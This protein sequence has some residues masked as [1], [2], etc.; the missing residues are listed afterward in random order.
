MKK[1]SCSVIICAAGKGERAGLGK[2]KLLFPLFGAPALYH[3]LKK[4]KTDWIDQVIVT[5]SRND[6][7]EISALCAPFGFETVIG[8]ATRT[9]S[10]KRALRYV[11]GEIVL[12]HDG[13]R[14]FVSE[15]LIKNCFLS[16]E[17]FGSG[18]AAVRFTDTAVYAAY[19]EITERLDRNSLYRVQTPQAFITEDIINAYR[20]AGDKL[21]TDDSAVYGEFIAPPRIVEGEESNVKLTYKSD[22][23]PEYAVL[24]V[25][26]GHRVGIGS[27]VHIFGDGDFVTL[28]GVKIECGKKLIAHSDGDVLLHAVC[29]AVLSA[30]GL[31]DIGHYFPDTDPSF[32]NANSLNLLKQTAKLALNAGYMPLNVSVT[33]Q[34]EKPKLAPHIDKIK[35]NI[36]AA[37]FISASDVAVAAGTCEGLGFVGE[38]LGIAAYAAVTLI[39]TNPAKI[40]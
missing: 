30:A 2:N 34:A 35:E 25:N 10:V 27:D 1:L 33:V 37:L 19:G 7:N 15:N 14:P 31:K 8:G 13:A 11:T 12:I 28:G 21:Y 22:Y 20:L 29:D 4:F 36:A 18:V 24:S 38:G 17:K 26:C 3:T 6:F 16:A 40:H 5:S 9:E 23:P 39:E 32:K